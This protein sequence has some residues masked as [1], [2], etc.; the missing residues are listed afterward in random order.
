MNKTSTTY[1]NNAEGAVTQVTH[2]KHGRRVEPQ[3]QEEADLAKAKPAAK[4][5]GDSKG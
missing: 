5:E 1:G 3:P 2:D 4:R